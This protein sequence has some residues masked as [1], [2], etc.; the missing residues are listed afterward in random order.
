MCVMHKLQGALNLIRLIAIS[1]KGELIDNISISQLSGSDIAWYWA[2]FVSPTEEEAKS[3]ET[4]FKFHPL[5]V[6]DCFHFLQRPKLDYYEG[7]SFFV[8]H[9]LN[10]ETMESNEVNVF[11]GPSYMVSFHFKKSVEVETTWERIK[12]GADNKNFN[13]VHAFH[14]LIDKIVDQYFPTLYLIEDRLDKLEK[15]EQ[16][17]RRA[18]MDEVFEKRGDLLR[19]RKSI[20]PMR[21]LLYRILNS[22]RIDLPKDHKVYFGDIYDHL[23]KLAEMVESNRDIT[24]DIRDS[25][26]SINSDRTNNI[27]MTLTVISAIFIPLTFIAGVY[28][29]NF[30]YMPELKWR[31]GY[32][33]ALGFMT[34]I[35]LTMFWWFRKKGWFGDD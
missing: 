25:Y 11:L 1:V 15:L 24:S 9:S 21:D 32:F 13:P 20:F 22:E 29:M 26:I 8:L 12:S 23:L 35:A 14:I 4:H 3:L 18:A 27:M 28:G 34:V 33:I 19:L 31:Y 17:S 5:A 7:Y 30:D 2:D 6:E 16:K 10:P